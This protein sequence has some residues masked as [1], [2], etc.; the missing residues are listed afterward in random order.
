MKNIDWKRKL[1]SRKFWTAASAFICA[2]CI[3]FG[4]DQMTVEKLAATVSALGVMAIYT[5]RSVP[6]LV[7]CSVVFCVLWP[8]AS[9]F[10]PT[11]A[12]ASYFILMP[13]VER[14][15]S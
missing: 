11:E 5:R 3:L 10:F 13:L 4:V 8:A 9:V 1:S 7:F 2:L 15:I 6:T 12:I 14:L